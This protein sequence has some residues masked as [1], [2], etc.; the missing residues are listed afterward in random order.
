M[1]GARDRPAN[2][3]PRT[4]VRGPELYRENLFRVTGLPV[5]AA[6]RVIR[7]QRKEFEM[8]EL[9]GDSPP[10]TKGRFALDP[11]PE[12]SAVQAAFEG[13]R[14]LERRLVDELFWFWRTGPSDEAPDTAGAADLDIEHDRA[15]AEH[16][17]ALDLEHLGRRRTLTASERRLRDESWA[18]AIT[19]WAALIDEPRLWERLHARIVAID[20]PRLTSA[21]L[22]DLLDD[23]PVRLLT[24][25]A[26]LALDMGLRNLSDAGRQRQLMDR[27]ISEAHLDTDVVDDVLRDVVAPTVRRI[28]AGCE[29]TRSAAVDDPAT[30]CAVGDRTLTELQPALTAIDVI[31]T[32]PHPTARAVRDQ[33]AGA[34]NVC[35]VQHSNAAGT[36]HRALAGL[37]AAVRL[38]TQAQRLANLVTTKNLIN[39]NLHG[40]REQVRAL[41]PVSR[42][43][44][45]TV[46]S[47]PPK[48]TP[49]RPWTPASHLPQQDPR[50]GQE[51]VTFLRQGRRGP[52]SYVD[53]LCRE[54]R[55]DLAH[56][57]LALWA[58]FMA[59]DTE[60]TRQV[61]TLLAKPAP[62]VAT[63][64][65]RPKRAMVL[66]CGIDFRGRHHLN[67]E[68][69]VA[70]QY[71][72]LFLV[73]LIP[74]AAYLIKA[75]AGDVPRFAGKVPLGMPLRYWRKFL[76]AVFVIT[77]T[78]LM[79]D[80]SAV[81]STLGIAVGLRIGFQVYKFLTLR[82]KI[83][84][85]TK[86]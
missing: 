73:P 14:D 28:E 18:Q 82:E 75:K 4:P 63:M 13:F 46:P 65:R 64:K 34:L 27:F 49:T 37:E 69:F 6:P 85:A 78:I 33:V 9:V 80:G 50:T 54:G 1:S 58:N 23:L 35:A 7:R 53:Q 67:A 32:A 3:A 43:Q 2:S 36:D 8:A 12:A 86:R 21:I 24:I 29:T 48:S 79:Y 68:E 59:N 41:T 62:F 39:D 52:W 60:I 40:I 72:F 81:V 17:T 77:L 44:R 61:V 15:V 56:D 45:D 20:D 51:I 74:I 31:L 57:A 16:C 70:R 10:T 11:P 5:D 25:H 84:L 19:S 66:G 22:D 30:A 55:P 83:R 47:R 76:T 71:L 38:L 42:F 26:Q